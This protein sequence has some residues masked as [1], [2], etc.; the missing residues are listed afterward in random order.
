[1]EQVIAVL[2]SEE[3][4]RLLH[5]FFYPSVLQ[6]RLQ[7]ANPRTREMGPRERINQ[8]LTTNYFFNVHR[9]ALF[10]PTQLLSLPIKSFRLQYRVSDTLIVQNRDQGPRRAKR[11]G[12]E[13]ELENS[14]AREVVELREGVSLADLDEVVRDHAEGSSSSNVGEVEGKGR[15]SSE[16]RPLFGRLGEDQRC[17]K[18][19]KKTVS[20]R[21][22]IAIKLLSTH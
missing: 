15:A 19:L 7:S 20:F 21:V 16:E 2:V 18:P 14:M 13:A 11:K 8:T 22:A 6:K 4:I 1:M 5:P 3:G 12:E 9:R 17:R 10:I